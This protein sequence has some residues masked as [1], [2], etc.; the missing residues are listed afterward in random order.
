ML[1][2]I[3]RFAFWSALIAPPIGMLLILPI[4][5][6][7]DGKWPI[8]E[9][10]LLALLFVSSPIAVPAA[11]VVGGPAAFITGATA[12]YMSLHAYN[13]PSTIAATTSVAAVA[14]AFTFQCGMLIVSKGPTTGLAEAMSVA[15]TG[16]ITTLICAG[17][18]FVF[19]RQGRR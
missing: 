8:L 3:L 18:Y 10:Q 2:S 12:K 11:Y 9:W 13:T 5:R 4:I 19:Y 15:A 7:L 17:L 6:L 14:S 16:A 1:K